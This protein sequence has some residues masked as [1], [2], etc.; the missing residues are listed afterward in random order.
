MATV[1]PDV[2]FAAGP[3]RCVTLVFL[4][5]L[6]FLFPRGAAGMNMEYQ[7]SRMMTTQAADMEP[8]E[9]YTFLTDIIQSP[10]ATLFD[11]VAAFETALSLT[12]YL[13]DGSMQLRGRFAPSDEAEKQRFG[14]FPEV[15]AFMQYKHDQYRTMARFGG[16][17]Q[18]SEA[19][20]EQLF[21][22]SGDGRLRDMSVLL[23][24]IH[25]DPENTTRF[26]VSE[27]EAL[28]PDTAD[29]VIYSYH[30]IAGLSFLGNRK[31][32][33]TL[34]EYIRREAHEELCEDA[35]FGLSLAEHWRASKVLRQAMERQVR[36]GDEGIYLTAAYAL[37]MKGPIESIPEFRLLVQSGANERV[38]TMAGQIAGG[39]IMDILVGDEQPESYT[40][41]FYVKVWDGFGISLKTGGYDVQWVGR[42]DSEGDS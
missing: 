34:D 9:A 12:G 23:L 35:L 1:K 36:P 21:T 7:Q 19:E 2:I 26:L 16:M 13:F 37:F 39:E 5:A 40:Q 22:V 27:L 31:V 29:A 33:D 25:A 3:S 4:A 10:D 14:V 6:L 41:E 38:R 30:L 8:E 11:K 17:M 15:A 28:E 42:E 24:A 20:I 32:V 18:L